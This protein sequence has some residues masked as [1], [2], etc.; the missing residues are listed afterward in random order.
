MLT[1]LLNPL[2][3]GAIETAL[4]RML[5]RDRALNNAR[6]RLT[7]KVLGVFVNEINSPLYLV[8]AITV[9]MFWA[10]GKATLSAALKRDYP[11]YRNCV[12]VNSLPRL[13]ALAI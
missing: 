2:F 6:Q 12:T 8:L 5:Y 9:W 10:R 4:N 1:P 13:S 7:G 3:T 11:C